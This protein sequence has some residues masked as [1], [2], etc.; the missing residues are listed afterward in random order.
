MNIVGLQ[1]V[2]YGAEDVDAATRFQED[3]GLELVENG[4]TGSDF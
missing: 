2:T 4:T 3:W 1:S